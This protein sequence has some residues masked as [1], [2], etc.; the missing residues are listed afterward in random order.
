[1][2]NLV[3]FFMINRYIYHQFFV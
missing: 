3:Y 1:M 2:I